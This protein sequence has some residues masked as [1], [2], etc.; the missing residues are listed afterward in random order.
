MCRRT[1]NGAV[2][3][4]IG[5]DVGYF[6]EL[7][8]GPVVV[9]AQLVDECLD[10]GVPRADGAPDGVSSAEEGGGSVGGDVAIDACDKH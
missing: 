9:L 8:F 5:T 1:L 2:K 6:N 7:E 10:V 3:G 4:A